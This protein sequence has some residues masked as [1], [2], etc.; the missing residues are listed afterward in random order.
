MAR[1]AVKQLS[2]FACEILLNG[3]NLLPK[4][5]SK[6]CLILFNPQTKAKYRNSVKPGHT[7]PREVLRQKV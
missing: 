5:S 7:D 1:L 4:G 6:F 2:I 3:K